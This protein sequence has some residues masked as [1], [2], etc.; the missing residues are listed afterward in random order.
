M[1]TRG[2]LAV[3]I[4]AAFLSI[5][6]N[7]LGERSALCLACVA[8]DNV[9]GSLW[10]SSG[11][12]IN[13]LRSAT[14]FDCSGTIECRCCGTSALATQTRASRCAWERVRAT[15]PQ[16]ILNLYLLPA[17]C[18]D[19]PVTCHCQTAVPAVALRAR[20]LLP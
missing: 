17:S 13:R 3:A 10:E 15:A 5:E 7:W 14:G 11:G 19:A 8:K 1:R 20:T 9:P 12:L 16:V 2:G 6:Q 18:S 4:A